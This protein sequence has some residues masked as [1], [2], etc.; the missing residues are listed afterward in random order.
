M[1]R[2]SR[3]QEAALSSTCRYDS[4]LLLPS[5]RLGLIV[6]VVGCFDTSVV[7]NLV[8]AFAGGVLG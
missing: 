2:V 5:V 8:V 1:C 3:P 7:L 4:V 6:V